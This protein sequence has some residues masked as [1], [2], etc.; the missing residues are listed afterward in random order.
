ML[1]T[2]YAPVVAAE[3]ASNFGSMLTRLAIPFL[4]TLWLDAT[5]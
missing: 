1:R 3:A 2:P 5:P 4:A